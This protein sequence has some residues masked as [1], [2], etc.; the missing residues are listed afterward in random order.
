M[1][2][3][4][5]ARKSSSG[6]ILPLAWDMH[7]HWLPG[8]DD[9]VAHDTESFEVLR[10]LIALGY[11]GAVAT[12]HIYNGIFDNSESQLRRHFADFQ[13]KAAVE[14]PGFRMQL[15]AEYMFDEI[16]CDRLLA[17]DQELLFFGP[18]RDLLLVELPVSGEPAALGEALDHFRRRKKRMII[19]HV[20]RYGYATRGAGLDKL[21]EWKSRGALLQ[22][23]ASSCAGAY[24]GTI[25]GTA[26]QIWREGFIDVVGSDLHHLTPGLK[27]H[28]D[29]LAWLA[30][31]PQDGFGFNREVA[32]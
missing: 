11:Q 8:V 27:S 4:F 1:F 15:S 13:A 10:G 22:L 26:R 3:R 32:I 25:R 12:P 6:G 24:G 29:G 17:D 23:N 14:V 30:E 9:G 7:A 28:A 5:F 31:H 16:F 19:A 20:E 18:R 21:C 2:S